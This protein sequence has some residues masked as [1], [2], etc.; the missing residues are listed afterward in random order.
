MTAP[1]SDDKIL[2]FL[3]PVGFDKVSCVLPCAPW[4]IKINPE[5][6][7]VL[8]VLISKREDAVH[9]MVLASLS[10]FFLFW[11][12]LLELNRKI[13]RSKTFK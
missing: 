3:S 8:P 2:L 9:Q 6:S 11:L 10:R 13:R 4:M 5:E 12:D 7:K 1:G